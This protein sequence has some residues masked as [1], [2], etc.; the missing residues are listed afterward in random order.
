MNDNSEDIFGDEKPKKKGGDIE[1]LVIQNLMKGDGG[2]AWMWKHLQDCGVFE[3]IFDVDT[4]KTAYAAG[5]RQA[6]LQLEND[7][8]T[9]APGDYLK[10][11]QE[12]IDG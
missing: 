7:L 11:I 10:M 12:N 5:K 2:R 3:N 9:A 6:G 4:H 1:S 8:K